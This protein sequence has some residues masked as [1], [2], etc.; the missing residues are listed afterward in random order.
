MNQMTSLRV[1]FNAPNSL[2]IILIHTNEIL[3]LKKN[4][5]R[6]TRLLHLSPFTKIDLRAV[7]SLLIILRNITSQRLDTFIQGIE[8]VER[9]IKVLFEIDVI[10]EVLLGVF[11]LRRGSLVGRGVELQPIIKICLDCDAK[12]NID[13]RTQR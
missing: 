13:I 4:K 5:A 10:G 2:I 6:P 3:V 1:L 8:K 7:P 11:G 9:D 12:P